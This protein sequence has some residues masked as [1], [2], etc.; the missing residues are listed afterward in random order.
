MRGVGSAGRVALGLC[1]VLGGCVSAAEPEPGAVAVASPTVVR[2][3][4]PSPAGTATPSLSPAPSPPVDV[5]VVPATIHI[6]Y[7]DAVMAV[8]DRLLQD[9]YVVLRSEGPGEAFMIA[10]LALYTPAEA[11]TQAD[12]WRDGFDPSRIADPPGR[13]TT[14]VVEI[15]HADGQCVHL[16]A[17]RDVSPLVTFAF[18]PVQPYHLR[19]ERHEPDDRNPTAW[20]IALDT[21]Y[22]AGVTAP[23]NLCVPEGS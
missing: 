20:R 9:A 15:L 3:P 2:L 17:E 19:L 10:M 6:A 7:L 13:P 4:P 8:L 16:A 11:G 22:R 5:S 21:F 18:E 14:R 1:A 23:T 12:F